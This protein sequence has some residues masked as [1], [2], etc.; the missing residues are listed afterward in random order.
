MILRALHVL[1]PA[2]CGEW[3]SGSE[4][5]QELWK[6]IGFFVG[7]YVQAT[8]DPDWSLSAVLP[9]RVK[10]A[11]K[12][13]FKPLLF[14]IHTLNMCYLQAC[15]KIPVTVSELFCDGFFYGTHG[16]G[17][18]AVSTR[19]VCGNEIYSVL[20]WGLLVKPACSYLQFSFFE[21]VVGNN[22][23]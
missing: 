7:L 14:K 9:W 21:V 1:M 2:E 18:S 22:T 20:F 3:S 19:A 23:T 10:S 8:Q 11:A 5:Q 16:S 4:E 15:N 17:F 12:K 6:R 13:D